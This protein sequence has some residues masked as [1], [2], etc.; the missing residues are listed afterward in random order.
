M[1]EVEKP[2]VI[3]VEGISKQFGSVRAI[4]DVSFE[5][6]QGEI[7]GFLGPN[8]AGKTTTMRILTG[9]FPPS[10]GKVF[11]QGQDL[12]KHPQKTKLKI[13]Y[14]PEVVNLYRDMQVIEMLQFA[15]LVR[16]VS[17]KTRNK[18]IEEILQKCGLWDVKKRLIQHLSKGYKQR[19]GLAQ[20]LVGNPEVLIL[21]EPTTG[22]DPKQII[23]IRA[24]IRELGRER[25]VILS[26]HILPEVGMVC[27]RVMIM[28]KGRVVASGTADELEAGL[29]KRHEIF[30]SIGDP[31]RKKEAWDLLESLA[32]VEDIAVIEESGDHIDFS[33]S[34]SKDH[35]LRPT[36]SRIFV[37]H[38]IPLLE[39]RSGRLS[40]EEIF[41]K[42]VLSE[43]GGK[44]IL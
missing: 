9:Y 10:G 23:E 14:L 6:K 17:R 35:D 32:G 28:N 26:T 21:D 44:K 12:F 42:I 37:Q 24:L 8:G 34:T 27:D 40:L 38:Q 39:I 31:R 3:R 16:R 2:S 43:S 5:V 4:E 20:A 30:V 13:G 19:V 29:K 11:I 15:A 22:L 36:I 33:L 25:T 18:H 1:P 41:M 7:L